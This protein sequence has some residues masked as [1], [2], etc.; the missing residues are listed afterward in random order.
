[1]AARVR[2]ALGIDVEEEAGAYGEFT[3]LVDDVPIQRGHP[4]ATMFAIVPSADEVVERVRERL[5]RGAEPP[6]SAPASS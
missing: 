1:V 2:C 3:V 6:A 5:A 4:I